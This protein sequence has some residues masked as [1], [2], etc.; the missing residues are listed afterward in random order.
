[1]QG[2]SARS[3]FYHIV[4]RSYERSSTFQIRQGQQASTQDAH[5][6]SQP[7]PLSCSTPS[8]EYS[9]GIW[10]LPRLGV[11]WNGM[12]RSDWRNVPTCQTEMQEWAS[13]VLAC[14]P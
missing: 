5:S 9:P 1:M 13:C 10:M 2:Y 6:R 4:V 12:Q 7:I 14:W 3:L 11:Q 8:L